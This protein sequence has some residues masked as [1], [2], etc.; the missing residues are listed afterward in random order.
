MSDDLPTPCRPVHLL[1]RS[2]SCTCHALLARVS[3][4]CY[5]SC[6]L[7]F[8][9]YVHHHHFPRH[10]FFFPPRQLPVLVKSSLRYH[11]GSLGSRSQV[12]TFATSCTSLGFP[13]YRHYHYVTST[14]II[15][16]TH[17]TCV[18]FDQTARKVTTVFPLN[19]YMTCSTGNDFYKQYRC[20]D[21]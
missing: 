15:C 6:Y 21:A 18:S 14:Y 7:P 1:T 20:S 5:R 3:S 8:P 11:V 16:S 12:K 10:V 9:Q 13:E 17:E 4:S 19:L 2:Q